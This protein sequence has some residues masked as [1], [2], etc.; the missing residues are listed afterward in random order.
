MHSSF[1]RF[2]RCFVSRLLRR[3]RR[4]FTG[5]PEATR[6]GRRLRDQVPF[7]IRDRDHRVIERRRDMNDTVGNVLLLFLTKDLLFSACFSHNF[8]DF[9]FPI[10]DCQFTVLHDANRKL[11]IGN[12]Q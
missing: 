10:S 4:P 5:A 9:Q 11:E 7:E 12:R 2:L 1:V 6:A 3:E 8:S